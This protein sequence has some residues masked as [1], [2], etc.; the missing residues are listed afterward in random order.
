LICTEAPVRTLIPPNAAVEKAKF[1][2]VRTKSPSGSQGHSYT[3]L[4]D[5]TGIARVTLF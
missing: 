1:P 4:E 3:I 2:I 5:D